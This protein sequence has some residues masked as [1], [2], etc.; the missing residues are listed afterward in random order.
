MNRPKNK[1]L[2]LKEKIMREKREIIFF[3]F[4]GEKNQDL[5]GGG[6]DMHPHPFCQSRLTRTGFR[7]VLV[8]FKAQVQIKM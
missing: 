2:V 5:T 7:P 4:L 3:W 6:H 8:Q 1:N